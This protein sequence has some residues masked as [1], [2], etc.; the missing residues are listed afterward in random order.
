MRFVSKYGLFGVQ[1]RP[2][3]EES[4]ASGGTR[5]IQEPVYA[6]FKPHRLLP[7]EYEFALANWSSWNGSYQMA[8]EVTTIP[9]EYR[10]GAFDSIEAQRQHLAGR[11]PGRGRADADQEREAT[12]NMLVVPSTLVAPPWPRYGVRG[13]VET[14][15]RRLIDD[16]HDLSEVLAYERGNQ[17]RDE[18]VDALETLAQRSRG[19]GGVPARG[20]PWLANAGAGPR[21]RSR[22]SRSTK[23]S[24]APTGA[25]SP[26]TRPSCAPRIASGPGSATSVS[27]AWSRSSRPGRNAALS[28][29]P[30]SAANRPSTSPASSGRHLARTVDHHQEELARLREGEP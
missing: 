30:R 22:S 15:V 14:L 11:A 6:M 20:D 8:D 29:A 21:S 23:S 10:I 26:C 25:A 18:I 16:G 4:F 24:T 5:T 12:D 1:I 17:D 19:A 9:P 27:S 2:K 28:A 3:I 7:G 13:D